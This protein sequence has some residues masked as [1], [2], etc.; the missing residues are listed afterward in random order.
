LPTRHSFE[1]FQSNLNFNRII[2]TIEHDG[3]LS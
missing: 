1:L 2:L 3:F